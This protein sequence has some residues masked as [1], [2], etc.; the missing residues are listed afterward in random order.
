VGIT[1]GSREE[2]QGRKGVAR[3]NERVI[4]NIKL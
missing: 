1:D 2:V 3:E 4:I